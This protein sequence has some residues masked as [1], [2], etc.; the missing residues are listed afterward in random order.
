MVLKSLVTIGSEVGMTLDFSSAAFL[1]TPCSTRA[2][3]SLHLRPIVNVFRTPLMQSG[4]LSDWVTALANVCIACAAVFAARQG[5]RGLNAWRA[6]AVG[7]RTMELAEEVLADFYQAQEIIDEARIPVSF[8]DEGRTRQDAD[9]ETEDDKRTLN[10]Y[11]VPAERLSKA[12]EFFAQLMA[13]RY[14]F[15]ALFGQE[16]AKPYD[17]L[18]NIR[19][20]I[21]GAVR[22]LFV[23]HQQR[24]EGTLPQDRK[25]W[26]ETI[27][28]VSEE[29]AIS[30][31]LVGAVGEIEKICRPIIDADVKGTN[32]FSRR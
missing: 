15:L 17:E 23:T 14:R 2:C 22:M 10:A 28:W 16:A 21:L 9:W 8:G 25:K 5:I 29:D 26:E 18:F 3:R 7:K 30:R 12:G 20:E 13:R 4:S 27:G 11:F 6:E 31:R 19:R 24:R 32:T 1:V